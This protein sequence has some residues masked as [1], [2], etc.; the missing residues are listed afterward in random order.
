GFCTQMEQVKSLYILSADAD[1]LFGQGINDSGQNGAHIKGLSNY[2]ICTETNS[3]VF[4]SEFLSKI[5][6]NQLY[7]CKKSYE[8]R[9][10]IKL[11]RCLRNHG[12]G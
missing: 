2:K 6:S 1:Q 3:D 8:N 12:L 9:F 4:L 10:D 7:S 5:Q 11:Q